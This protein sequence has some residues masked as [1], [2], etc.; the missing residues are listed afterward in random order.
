MGN[1]EELEMQ[2]KENEKLRKIANEN[3]KLRDKLEEYQKT[4]K[5]YSDKKNELNMEVIKFK[6]L[7]NNMKLKNELLNNNVTEYKSTIES[8]MKENS[9]LKLK[10]DELNKT[11]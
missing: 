11:K 8:C 2:K 9:E 6:N 10:I 1:S 7:Y 5:E 3:Y 4:I